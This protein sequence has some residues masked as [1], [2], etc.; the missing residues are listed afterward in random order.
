MRGMTTGWVLLLAMILPSWAAAA[1]LPTTLEEDSRLRTLALQRLWDVSVTPQQIQAEIHRMV[2]DSRAPAELR[3]RFEALGGDP[4]QVAESLVRPLLLD[5]MLRQHYA[6]DVLLHAPL[7]LR[8]EAELRN[9]LSQASGR[10]S[11]VEWVRLP[12]GG[13]PGLLTEPEK[14]GLLP[15]EWGAHLARLQRDQGRLQETADSF[16]VQQL[17]HAGKDRIR[18][19]MVVWSKRSFEDWWSEQRAVLLRRPAAVRESSA[20]LYVLPEVTAADC[21][22]EGWSAIKLDASTPTARIAHSMVWTGSEIIVWGG[23]GPAA[24]ATGAR[25]DPASDSWAPTSSVGAPSARFGHSAVWTGSRMLVWGGFGSAYDNSGVAYD[26]VT[27]TWSPLAGAGTLAP[28]YQHSALW[29]GSEMILWG[30]YNGAFLDSGARYQ[31]SRGVWIDL[32]PAGSPA[33]RHLHTA[34]WSVDGMIV[35]GGTNGVPMLSGA[36]WNPSSN[37]WSPTGEGVNVPLARRD[38]TAVWTGSEMAVWGG[39][40][41]LIYDDGSRYAPAT[42]SWVPV[43]K[44]A[45]N[46]SVRHWHTA[47]WTG[48]DMMI[49]GGLGGGV[50]GSRYAPAGDSWVALLAGVAAPQERRQHTA[51][52]TDSE[53][54]RMVVWGGW[55]TAYTDTGGAYCASCDARPWYPDVDGDGLGAATGLQ[56]GCSAPLGF[57]DQSGDCDD[58]DAGVWSLPGEVPQLGFLAD[59]ETL[60]WQ[61]AQPAGG[62]LVAYDVIRASTS[63]GFDAAGLCVES[64]DS[65]DS[66]AWDGDAPAANTLFFYLVRPQ[67]ACASGSPGVTSA[68]TLRAVRACP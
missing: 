20:V 13:Q 27:D 14:I 39:A 36:L 18:V 50:N 35:W 3:R 29:T 19:A 9:E 64:D 37:Q 21:G 12:V 26:P 44:G 16:Q 28:R 2:R 51:V 7:R 53:M 67:N 33:A 5:R 38:H 60:Q 58:D 45:D 59:G 49:W 4:Q 62:N 8:A 10:Y 1:E 42:D 63:T 66:E 68:G 22:A 40:G 61:A 30:G 32:P 41:D 54:G 55:T 65:T 52:W 47:V 6:E 24:L 23:R 56:T 11:E 15:H 43:T 34:V 17:L 57:V 46:P 25:Y 31:P 48:T